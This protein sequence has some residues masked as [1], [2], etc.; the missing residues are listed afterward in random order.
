MEK[1][2]PIWDRYLESIGEKPETTKL[3]YLLVDHFT[4]NRESADALF[5]LAL[6]GIKR[7]TTGSLW[8]CDYFKEPIMQ[9]GDL[10]ILTNYD[11][12][13][14]C[15]IR[16]IKTTIK[17]FK[18]VTDEDAAI[19]GEGDKSLA[20]WRMAHKRFFEEECK[21]IGKEFTEEMPVIFEEFK[22]EYADF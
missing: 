21:K 2:Y 16:T 14:M 4:N 1:K 12:S 20:Y 5:D 6:A 15:I 19:E 22:I 10:S 11:E 8:A 9:P 17:K 13:R 7:A 3:K 18:E